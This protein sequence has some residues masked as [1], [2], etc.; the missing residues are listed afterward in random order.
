MAEDHSDQLT[1]F[2]K[3]SDDKFGA[4]FTRSSL[5][6]AMK[7]RVLIA[8]DSPVMR[9]AVRELL[10]AEANIEIVGEAI[11]LSEMSEMNKRLQPDVVIMDLHMMENDAPPLISD[12]QGSHTLMMSLCEPEEG[13]RKAKDLGASAY[14]DKMNLYDTL[15][16][17]IFELHQTRS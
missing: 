2:T 1:C 10:T 5:Q 4:P 13:V 11:N 7:I 16:P 6:V 14:L 9:K 15:I 8:D 3:Y 12:D 17:K